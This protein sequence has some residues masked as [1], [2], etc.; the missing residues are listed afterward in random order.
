MNDWEQFKSSIQKLVTF[1]ENHAVTALMGTHIEMSMTPGKDY[2]MGVNY[3][4]DEVSLVLTTS[5]L[6]L[7]NNGLRMMQDADDKVYEKFIIEPVGRLQK[8]IGG[9]IGWFVS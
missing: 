4:P 7:L 1:T 2:P 8:I 9:I 6:L 5:D 3:Q